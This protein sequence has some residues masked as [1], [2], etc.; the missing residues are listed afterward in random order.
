MP[1]TV[2]GH[3][4]HS[5]RV[6]TPTDGFISIPSMESHEVKLRELARRRFRLSLVLTAAMI[7]VYFGFVLLIAF[8]KTFMA[9]ELIPGLT[10]GILAGAVVI[11]ASWALTLYYVRWTNVHYDQALKDLTR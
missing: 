4:F 3:T 7:A 8:D 10:I 2:G 11:V 6:T 9:R 5:D 1:H